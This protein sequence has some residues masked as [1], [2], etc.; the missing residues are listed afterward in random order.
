MKELLL[1]PVSVVILAD[2]LAVVRAG[3]KIVGAVMTII[4]RATMTITTGPNCHLLLDI[5]VLTPAL[6]FPTKIDRD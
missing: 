4:R 3:C 2:K 6:L 1:Y 5:I